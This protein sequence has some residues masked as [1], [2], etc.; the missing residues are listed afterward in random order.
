MLDW[1]AQYRAGDTPCEL[2][3]PSPPLVD[4]VDA[5]RACLGRVLVP[6]CGRGDDALYVATLGADVSGW[7][8]APSAIAAARAAAQGQGLPVTF[9]VRDALA[10]ELRDVGAFDTWIEHTFFCALPPES[11]P[12]YAESAAAVLRPGGLLLGIF[13]LDGRPGGPPYSTTSADLLTLFRP[14]F[15]LVRATPAMN[16]P[17]MWAGRET[18]LAF[19]RRDPRMTARPA[20]LSPVVG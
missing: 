17:G 4:L 13:V 6:G 19:A 9:D 2:G 3:R 16:S 10:P 5:Y 7:D 14:W 18:M 15:D 8:P 11:R 12:R 1:E 20:H